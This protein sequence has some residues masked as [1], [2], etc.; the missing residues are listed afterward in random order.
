MH[1]IVSGWNEGQ[2][3]VLCGDSEDCRSIAVP[4]ANLSLKLVYFIVCKLYLIKVDLS[5]FKCRML[6]EKIRNSTRLI[7]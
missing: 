7:V 2:W 1:K 6:S 3:S 5:V 4:A